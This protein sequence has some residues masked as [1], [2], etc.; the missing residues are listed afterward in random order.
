M[1]VHRYNYRSISSFLEIVSL[2]YFKK[3][4]QTLAITDKRKENENIITTS[5][6]TAYQSIPTKF[7]QSVFMSAKN[8]IVWVWFHKKRT[9]IHVNKG[10]INNKIIP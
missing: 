5:E 1:F 3:S 4:L 2:C 7:H 6:E 9:L 10:Y 8:A